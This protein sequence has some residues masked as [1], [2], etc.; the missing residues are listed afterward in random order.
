MFVLDLQNSP[1][2]TQMRRS[3][4]RDVR[5]YGCTMGELLSSPMAPMAVPYSTV[6]PRTL[7]VGP[8]ESEDVKM[9]RS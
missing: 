7:L 4:R 9:R 1:A 2:D 3:M 8:S 6:G 5:T